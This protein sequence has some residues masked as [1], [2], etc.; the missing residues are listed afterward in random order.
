MTTIVFYNGT[1]YADHKISYPNGTEAIQQLLARCLV[2]PPESFECT[3]A[4]MME[5]FSFAKDGMVAES[6]VDKVHDISDMGLT[7]EGERIR[8]VAMAGC[9]CFLSSIFAIAGMVTAKSTMRDF[10]EIYEK[11]FLPYTGQ[12]ATEAISQMM[13]FTDE[14]VYLV[15]LQRNGS[16]GLMD[17][18]WVSYKPELFTGD[19]YLII[20]TGAGCFYEEDEVKGAISAGALH[21]ISVVIEPFRDLENILQTVS[22]N[23]PLTGKVFSQYVTEFAKEAGC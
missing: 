12:C 16:T 11:E 6:F 9:T 3:F 17:L 20:G 10:L 5:R 4:R 21:L 7:I 15:S 2:T 19:R 22:E 14:H 1:I 13:L 23:D 8:K 18:D